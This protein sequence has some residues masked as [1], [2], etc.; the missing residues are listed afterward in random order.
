M[1]EDWPTITEPPDP[2]PATASNALKEARIE[3]W[4]DLWYQHEL[5]DRQRGE[6][7]K[8]IRR[9]ELLTNDMPSGY[10][11]TR[12]RASLRMLAADMDDLTA[13]DTHP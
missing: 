5:H 12:I 11:R 3:L 2:L 4:R 10:K 6:V 7:V 13:H 8:V 9:M 1:S